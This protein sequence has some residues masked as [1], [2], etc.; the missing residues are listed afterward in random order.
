M[1]LTQW[2]LAPIFLHV[3]LATSI[4]A[5]TILARIRAVRSREV[6]L[7]AIALDTK[8]WPDNVRKLGNNFDNQFD[9]PTTWYA[10]CALLVATAK[11]D[12]AFVVMSWAFLAT[13]VV[14]TYIH[15]GRNFVPN[16]M[17]A[18]LAG[19]AVL[20][21]MWGWFGLRLFFLG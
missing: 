1:T 21:V 12:M 3:A 15:T 14:H 10:L 5:R 7:S 8:N 2:M 20:L 18:Y 4:G 19:Y 9:V 17:Y 16:R 6:R 11:I 13:R